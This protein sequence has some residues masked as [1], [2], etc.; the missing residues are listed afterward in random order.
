MPVPSGLSSTVCST[1]TVASSSRAGL[2][3]VVPSGQL[4]T[5]SPFSTSLVPSC[6]VA[7]A[8]VPHT[9]PQCEGPGSASS[10]PGGLAKER[11]LP[12]ESVKGRQTQKVQVLHPSRQAGQAGYLET[13]EAVEVVVAGPSTKQSADNSNNNTSSSGTTTL[14]IEANNSPVKIRLP[15]NS[16]VRIQLSSRNGRPSNMR[17][18][19]GTGGRRG[20]EQLSD[21]ESMTTSEGSENVL[22]C[23]HVRRSRVV[24]KKETGGLYSVVLLIQFLQNA[25]HEGYISMG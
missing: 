5:D 21:P 11:D 18:V 12:Q 1:T 23:G 6:G 19:P 14:H 17:I 15:S 2:T 7:T 22:Q 13:V 3:S 9:R 10:V 25:Q 8:T 4:T 20:S 16:P 24:K